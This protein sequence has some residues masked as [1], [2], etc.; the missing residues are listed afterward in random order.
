MNTIGLILHITAAALLT[1]YLWLVLPGDLRAPVALAALAI[2]P[3][4][5]VAHA[6]RGLRLFLV[7]YDGKL[8]L[9]DALSAHF[10]AAGVSSL[11][12]YKLGELYRMLM[13]HGL[14]VGLT[15]AV[16]AIWIERVFDAILVAG[17]L[18]LL[19][20]VAGPTALAG[21]AW[22]LPL[23][24][25]F[26]FASVLLFLVLPENLV[27]VKRHLISKHN[28]ATTLTILRL[29]DRLHRVLADASHIWRTRFVTFLWLSL[30][31]WS[32]EAGCV[33]AALT[34]T[35]GS[36]DLAADGARIL[37]DMTLRSSPWALVGGSGDNAMACYRLG[38]VD[39]LAITALGIA[40]L[41]P[42]R[43]IYRLTVPSLTPE[44]LSCP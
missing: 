32:L 30:G 41:A 4:Y 3:L 5:L 29:V 27:L 8:R 25:V 33:L 21:V 43:W 9:R 17:L 26:L 36:L 28:N 22:F 31:I 40:L 11:I 34:L 35:G 16:I 7:L 13:V 38:T 39:L 23:L 19:V 18:A 12:P 6:L 44:A 2:A 20:A 1:A 10:H 24:A 15:R 42:I 14:G 37:N